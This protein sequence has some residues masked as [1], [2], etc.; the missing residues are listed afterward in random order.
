MIE[1]SEKTSKRK[2]EKMM[3]RVN[4]KTQMEL[5]S[6]LFLSSLSSFYFF[7]L[8]LSSS[9]QVFLFPSFSSRLGSKSGLDL[10][11]RE[12]RKRR[13]RERKREGKRRKNW[14]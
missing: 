4:H 7:I 6:L 5:E 14:I 2:S 12:E 10:M 9:L 1:V 3:K 13:K 11:A 8:F